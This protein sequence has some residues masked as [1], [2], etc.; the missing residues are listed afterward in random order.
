MKEY[1]DGH[2][3]NLFQYILVLVTIAL[4]VKGHLTEKLA[5]VNNRFKIKNP[6]K[7]LHECSGERGG[8]AEQEEKIKPCSS[9]RQCHF[10][11][12]YPYNV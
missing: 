5:V 10:H 6:P 8:D 3:I 7:K 1:I 11:A 9:L 12:I 4:G 2:F